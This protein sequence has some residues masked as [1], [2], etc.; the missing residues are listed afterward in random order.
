[1]PKEQTLR[2]IRLVATDA[3]QAEAETAVREEGHSLRHGE[4]MV[5]RLCAPVLPTKDEGLR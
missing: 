4:V 5:I 3:E 2:L 1:M